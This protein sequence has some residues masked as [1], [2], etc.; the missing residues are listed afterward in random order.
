V[1]AGLCLGH[2]VVLGMELL[3]SGR[4]GGGGGGGVVN[5]AG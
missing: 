3:R 2:H 5:G 4:S 1:D